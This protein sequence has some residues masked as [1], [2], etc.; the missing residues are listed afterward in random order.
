MWVFGDQGKNRSPESL[1][2]FRRRFANPA[3]QIPGEMPERGRGFED[4]LGVWIAQ[5]EPVTGRIQIPRIEMES[6]V[7]I[8][9][10]RHVPSQIGIFTQI[11]LGFKDAACER[12][13]LIIDEGKLQQRKCLRIGSMVAYRG[14]R[15]L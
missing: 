13:V 9:T 15:A 2:L 6:D 5:G 4:F 8:I 14:D 11:R 12:P 7:E 3:H 10:R 1:G